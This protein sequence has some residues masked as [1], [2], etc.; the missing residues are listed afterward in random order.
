VK[1]LLPL[2]LFGAIDGANA[3]TWTVAV[4]AGPSQLDSRHHDDA[5][6]DTRAALALRGAWWFTPN[7]ALE[8][9]LVHA[10]TAPWSQGSWAG[11]RPWSKTI[12]TRDTTSEWA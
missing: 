4:D 5:D 12:P 7:F 11:R 1:R 10:E 2:F 9:G 8:G 3:G 6:V